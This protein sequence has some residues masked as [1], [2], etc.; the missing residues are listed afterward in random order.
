MFYATCLFML[1]NPVPQ[2]VQ[3]IIRETLYLQHLCSSRFQLNA[4]KI[5]YTFLAADTIYL[6]PSHSHVRPLIC[7]KIFLISCCFSW[8]SVSAAFIIHSFN[9]RIVRKWFWFLHNYL[10]YNETCLNCGFISFS[11]DGK[12]IPL[13]M[14]KKS[15][16]LVYL[17]LDSLQEHQIYLYVNFYNGGTDKILCSWHPFTA[18]KANCSIAQYT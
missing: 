9:V 12:H 15:L 10:R 18:N 14:Q 6:L 11:C 1:A 13:P 8:H 4:P 7:S 5:I 3:W 16:S 17:L 2:S